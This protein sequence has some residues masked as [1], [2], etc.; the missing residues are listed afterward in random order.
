MNNV[1]EQTNFVSPLRYIS[2]RIVEYDIKA[3]NVSILF[4][5]GKISQD[6]YNYL[7]NLPKQIREVEVGLMIKADSSYYNTISEGIKEYK[8]KLGEANNINEYQIVRIANDAVYINTPLDLKYTLFDDI[9]LFKQKSISDV[10][11]TI[12]KINVFIT[13]VDNSVSIDV[14]GLGDNY[15]LHTNGILNIISTIVYMVERSSIED[16]IRFLSEF[17]DDYINHRVAIDYYREFN[18]DSMYTIVMNDYCY[19][20]YDVSPDYVQYMDIS[21]NLYILR[22]LWSIILSLYNRGK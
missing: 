3:A 13:F 20:L 12:N 8:V 14:K 7:M 11:I 18:S 5:K 1:L 22:D 6:K 9:V 15:K 21:C 16:A 17:I 2:G 10:M 4:A 19:R